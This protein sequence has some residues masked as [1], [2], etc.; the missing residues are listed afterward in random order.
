MM[1]W[2]EGAAA[3]PVNAAGGPPD[4][5]AAAVIDPL[6]GMTIGSFRIVKMIGKGGM[7]TVY[8]G[9]QTVIGS[10]VAIKILH[11]H[12][13]SNASLVSRFY[14]E[15]RAVNLIGHENIVNIFDMN[16]IPPNR[17]YLIMEM[18]EGRPLNMLA[19]GPVAPEIVVPILTQVCDALEAAHHH[20]VVHRDLK[21]ENIFLIK[22]GR[23]ENFAKI[24]DFGIAKLFATEAPSEQTAAGMIVGT[25]EYMAPEQCT[26][27]KID[28]R[29]DLYALGVIAYQLTTGRLPFSGGGLTGLLLAHQSKI[30]TPPHQVNPHIPLEL[31]AVIMRSLAKRPEDRFQTADELASA[32]EFAVPPVAVGGRAP[33]GSGAIPPPPVSSPRPPGTG[34]PPGAVSPPPSGAGIPPGSVAPDWT[35]GGTPPVS[36]GAPLQGGVVAAAPGAW[37][38]P[39]ASTP[40]VPPPPPVA[41]PQPPAPERNDVPT[42]PLGAAAANPWVPPAPVAPPPEPAAKIE[43]KPPARPADATPMPAH[44]RHSAT[45]DARVATFDGKSLGALKCQD[46]SKGG[47]F[48]C[49]EGAVPAMFTRVKVTFPIAGDLECVGEVVRQVTRDQA[50]AWGMLPGFGVQFAT[51]SAAQKEALERVVQ[52]LPAAKAALPPKSDRD[53][54]IAETTLGQFRKR[55]NGDHYVVLALAPDAEVS[56]VRARGREARRE[57]EALRS[58]GLSTGQKAQLETALAKVQAAIETLGTA[59]IR[60]AF[61]AHR[62]NYKGVARCIAAGITVTEIDAIRA[63]FLN[64]HAGA[65]A[66]A[67][68]KFLG[69]NAYETNNQ[70]PKALEQYEDALTLDP[71][72]LRY[73][74]R[75]WALKRKVR[76]AP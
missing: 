2:E 8:Q 30:A 11:D 10:K 46:I 12:L 38:S 29:A 7:G 31:S 44:A 62:G 26:G 5:N 53:D 48:L 51:L 63:T 49:T 71:L 56:E 55:I 40:I 36:Y 69:G 72:N 70:V 66:K 57:L 27:E 33:M 20:G 25:P 76:P 13:A 6:I 47:C 34:T 17:Y 1:P 28:G 14:A 65:E 32:L 75:Y 73:Q 15:A 19:R 60:M 59:Q 42:P 39:P 3:A 9:E 58:R 37:E 4:P 61:D 16:V 74:Q 50:A 52:G 64:S 18:L 22:R 24:L 45:F 43:P 68:V 23:N 35:A 41:S 54:P 67:H 21:P